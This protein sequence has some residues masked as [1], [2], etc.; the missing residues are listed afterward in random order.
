MKKPYVTVVAVN[1]NEAMVL[2]EMGFYHEDPL[3]VIE[4]IKATADHYY[5]DQYKIF[6][7]PA[8]RSQAY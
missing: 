3:E 5:A 1:L 7:V 8:Q 4:E 2:A 6:K